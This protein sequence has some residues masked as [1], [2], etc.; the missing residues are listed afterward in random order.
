MAETLAPNESAA[1]AAVETAGDGDHRADNLAEDAAHRAKNLAED[2]AHR[3]RNL[4]EDAAHR[5]RNLAEDSARR[6]SQVDE[7]QP[8][9]QDL[10]TDRTYAFSS[11]TFL[12]ALSFQEGDTLKWCQIETKSFSYSGSSSNLGH[13]REMI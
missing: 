9:A 7:L 13:R 1:A 2:A 8:R 5:A 10:I 6:A 4:V 3:A 11:A 12:E